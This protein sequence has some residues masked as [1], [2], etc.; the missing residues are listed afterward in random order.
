MFFA[1]VK[2]VYVLGSFIENLNKNL[3]MF[4]LNPVRLLARQFQT[5]TVGVNK[6]YFKKTN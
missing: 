5:Q 1:G 3:S 2:L 6:I 4:C